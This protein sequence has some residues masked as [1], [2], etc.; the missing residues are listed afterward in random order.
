MKYANAEIV[1]APFVRN[2]LAII[3]IRG[4]KGDEFK[5]NGNS[6]KNNNIK[7]IRYFQQ[8]FAVVLI[9]IG[10]YPSSYMLNEP[11][12]I[13]FQKKKLTYIIRAKPK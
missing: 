3:I 4:N 12:W 6:N 10:F 5:K 9:I 2:W 7:E 1:A 8:R 13:K 11:T